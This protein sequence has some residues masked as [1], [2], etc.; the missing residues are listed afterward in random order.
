MVTTWMGDC[1]LTGKPC[2]YV[3]SHLCQLSFS[4][5]GGEVIE[6]QPVCLGLLGFRQGLFSSVNLNNCSVMC[7]TDHTL[8]CSYTNTDESVFAWSVYEGKRYF[9]CPQNAKRR[10]PKFMSYI[11]KC[12]LS[13][14]MCHT[15]VL[16]GYMS[17]IIGY[18]EGM[19][20]R[21]IYALQQSTMDD[22][23]A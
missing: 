17:D 4:Y 21:E 13:S 7:V 2:L 19:N 22:E 11:C 9:R 6:Y 20:D 10:Q 3:P 18:W 15:F 8:L 12:W 23:P 16:M 1:L 14:N 5:L